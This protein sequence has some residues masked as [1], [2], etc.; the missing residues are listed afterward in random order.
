MR[1]AGW[2]LLCAA[3]ALAWAEEP[4]EPGAEGEEGRRIVETLTE[5]DIKREREAPPVTIRELLPKEKISL[6]EAVDMPS[7]I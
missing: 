1:G 5:D 6:D 3:S 2:A 7:D 4:A